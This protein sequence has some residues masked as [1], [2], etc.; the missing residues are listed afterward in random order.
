MTAWYLMGPHQEKLLQLW[1]DCADAQAIDEAFPQVTL[2]HRIGCETGD[3]K[4]EE[5][6]ESAAYVKADGFDSRVTGAG[7]KEKGAMALRHALLSKP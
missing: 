2:A 7:T 4:T 1:R 3:K 5:G 6:R